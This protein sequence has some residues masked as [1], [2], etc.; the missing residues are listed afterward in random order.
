[1]NM[2]LFH[3]DYD[4]EHLE[5]VKSEMKVLG[6]PTIKAVYDE[7]YG[8]WFAV[9]GCHRI[10][11]AKELGLTPIIEDVTNQETVAMQLND[12]TVEMEMAELLEI[13]ERCIN[14]TSISFNTED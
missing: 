12:E 6:A 3:N 8:T 2:I 5:E 1:M 13:L 4:K 10:R 9:E 11:A 14:N 7:C